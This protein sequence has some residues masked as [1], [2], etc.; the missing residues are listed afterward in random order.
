MIRIKKEQ[1]RKLI[2]LFLKDKK[3]AV[4]KKSTAF[5]YLNLIKGCEKHYGRNESIYYKPR[6]IQ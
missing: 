3:K 2:N 6:E 1:M 5:L 4:D